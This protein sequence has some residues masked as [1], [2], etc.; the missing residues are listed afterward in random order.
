MKDGTT[1]KLTE[2]ELFSVKSNPF[3]NITHR[4]RLFLNKIQAITDIKRSI[5]YTLLRKYVKL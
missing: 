4:E 1:T 5:P 3:F 2:I